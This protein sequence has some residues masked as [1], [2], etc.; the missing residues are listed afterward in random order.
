[1]QLTRKFDYFCD[2]ENFKIIIGIMTDYMDSKDIV[3][4]IVELH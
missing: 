4:L 1:M 2:I 3:K